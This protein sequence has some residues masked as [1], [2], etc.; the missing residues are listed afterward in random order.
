L[1]IGGYKL[2]EQCL[3]DDYSRFALPAATSNFKTVHKAKMKW[4]GARTKT[5]L[6]VPECQVFGAYY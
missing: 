5:P 1:Q 2:F 4:L 6:H 3:I